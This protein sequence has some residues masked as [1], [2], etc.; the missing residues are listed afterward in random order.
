[1]PKRSIGNSPFVLVY[2]REARLPISLE[3]PSLEVA[4]QLELVEDNAMSVRMAELMELEEKRSRAIKTLEVH[5]QKV[6]KSFDRKS[7]FRIFREGDLVLKWDSD[8]EKPGRHSKFDP[9]WS[10]P[11]LISSCKQSNAFQLSR[12]NG[13][14]LPIPVN[15]IYLKPYF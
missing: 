14:I 2:G 1:M 7:R 9:L 3:F 12:P 13:E 15:G 6:K 4:H 10:G 11:Y 5:Q 8:R